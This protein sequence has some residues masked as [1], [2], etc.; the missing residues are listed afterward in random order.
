MA[1]YWQ[2]LLSSLYPSS[3]HCPS[4]GRVLF[5]S[6]HIICPKCAPFVFAEAPA[7]CKVCGCAMRGGDVCK[8]CYENTYLY[9]RGVSMLIYNR[10]TRPIIHSIKYNNNT[11]LAY[12]LGALLSIDILR[13]TDILHKVDV[14]VPIPLAPLRYEQRG[15]NQAQYIAE[16][17]ASATSKPVEAC[18]LQKIR[19]TAD[20]IGLSRLEREDNLRDSFATVSSV[21]KHKNVLLIDDV[22]TTGATVQACTKALR[23]GGCN[24]VYFAVIASSLH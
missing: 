21:L 4:C 17:L 10:Y 11:D 5:D 9:E 7:Y 1:D 14:I 12:R 3:P 15:Y 22:L 6:N 23:E 24:K 16:G 19:E 18:A 20:Q 8:I 13:K 2:R